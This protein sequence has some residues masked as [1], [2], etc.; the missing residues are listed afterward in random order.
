METYLHPGKHKSCVGIIKNPTI[1][2]TSSKYQQ[3]H[4]IMEYK[5]LKM[6][7]I[8]YDVIKSDDHERWQ[9]LLFGRTFAHRVSTKITRRSSW[10]LICIVDKGFVIFLCSRSSMVGLIIHGDLCSLIYSSHYG[11]GRTR[12][13]LLCILD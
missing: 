13:S 9:C 5:I 1:L 6:L 10:Y 11:W 12:T 8:T 3:Q 2:I 4:Y 7:Q